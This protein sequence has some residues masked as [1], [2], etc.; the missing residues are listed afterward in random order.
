MNNILPTPELSP[1]PLSVNLTKKTPFYANDAC[2]YP[3]MDSSISELPN[4][5]IQG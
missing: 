3:V 5:Y 1:C 4:C 2:K